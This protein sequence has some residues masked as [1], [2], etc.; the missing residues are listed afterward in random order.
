MNFTYIFNELLEDKYHFIPIQNNLEIKSK[1]LT[2]MNQIYS[3]IIKSSHHLAIILI[4]L[5]DIFSLRDNNNIIFPQIDLTE[6]IQP[7]AIIKINSNNKS[8]ELKISIKRYK[9][10]NY[11]NSNVINEVN[12][13]N[14]S[15]N[16]PY[17]ELEISPKIIINLQYCFSYC[18]SYCYNNNKIYN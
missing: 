3:H 7:F 1:D 14:E 10:E 16:I 8:L 13:I 12:D 18:Y 2:Q 15:T 5:K 9:P 6:Q 17:I 11:Y 4:E